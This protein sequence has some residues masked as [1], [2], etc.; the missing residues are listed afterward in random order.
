VAKRAPADAQTELAYIREVASQFYGN[1][2]WTVPVSNESFARYGSSTTPTI[3]LIDRQGIVRMYHPGQM[4]RAE[5][6]PRIKA[7]V[8]SRPTDAR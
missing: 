6:E 4:T 2:E 7:I 5:L 3:V 8:E 1:V